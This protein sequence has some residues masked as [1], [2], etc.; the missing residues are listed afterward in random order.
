MLTL[1]YQEV[2]L[3]VPIPK[4]V[5]HS[6][7]GLQGGISR[8]LCHRPKQRCRPDSGE[9][10]Q[11]QGGLR[12]GQLLPDCIVVLVNT[13]GVPTDVSNDLAFVTCMHEVQPGVEHLAEL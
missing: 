2:A 9:F 8:W 11:E 3:I 12:D 5:L 1:P 13:I 7:G 6:G 4:R 10:D